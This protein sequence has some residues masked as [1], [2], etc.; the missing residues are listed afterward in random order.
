LPRVRS[1][2]DATDTLRQIE[3]DP[4]VHS[5]VPASQECV[6]VV[7]K[8]AFHDIDANELV[9]FVLSFLVRVLNIDFG[10]FDLGP[11]IISESTGNHSSS[12][13]QEGCI[14]EIPVDG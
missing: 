6:H 1:F 10:V 13:E 3:L 8:L 4:N 7:G 14:V 9:P 12:L 5:I 11:A 2:P